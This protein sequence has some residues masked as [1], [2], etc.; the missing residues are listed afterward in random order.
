[1]QKKTLQINYGNHR[2]IGDLFLPAARGPFPLVIFGH[3][4][5]MT[6]PLFDLGRLAGHGIA[7]YAPDFA[8]GSPE[9][10]SGGSALH[11]SVMT[12]AHEMAIALQRLASNKNIDPN[13][14][15]LCGHSQ[16]GYAAT[17]AGIHFSTMIRGLV[18]LS[19]AYIISTYAHQ[20]FSRPQQ[21]ATFRF[22]NM[23]VGRQYY[24]DLVNYHPLQEMRKFP[25][26]V[27]IIHG[28]R[29]TMV[30]I[31]YAQRAA[32]AFP[33]ARLIVAHGAGHMLEGYTTTI[34]DQIVHLVGK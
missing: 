14:I 9:S 29:D 28:D 8:G 19:P 31:S 23:V 7:V 25:K 1:M 32:E 10:R 2:L 13:R 5:G 22:I 24:Q 6:L 18:L 11:M 20:Y 34:I 27:T 17:V 15:I 3:G 30:P 16:G 26:P 12:E 21:A 33:H 4:Y